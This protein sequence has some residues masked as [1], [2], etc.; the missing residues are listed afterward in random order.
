MIINYIDI[1]NQKK[2]I[3]IVIAIKN[4]IELSDSHGI[5]HPITSKD[6]Y[7][8]NVTPNIFVNTICFLLN[9]SI[10]IKD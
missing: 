10:N 1:I 8:I 6:R 5:N 3:N 2:E 7:I 9:L 4:N